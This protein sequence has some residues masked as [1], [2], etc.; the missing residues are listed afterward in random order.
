MFSLPLFPSVLV[1]ETS[2]DLAEVKLAAP[3]IRPGTVAK[4]T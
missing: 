1:T 2:F 4:G 3:S